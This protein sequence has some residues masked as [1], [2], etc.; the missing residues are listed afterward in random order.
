M[1]NLY[2]Y[3]ETTLKKDSSKRT[4]PL[5]NRAY[6]VLDYLYNNNEKNSTEDYVC[7]NKNGNIAN[8][9]NITRTLNAMLVRAKCDVQKCGLHALRH[10]FGSFLV[11][12]GVDIATVSKLMGHRDIT[13]TYNIY[14]H[15][16]QQQ[17][18]DAINV[19]DKKKEDE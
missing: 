19:F 8:Q 18:I 11:S 3:E 5:S 4:I 10:S 6:E 17:Q 1:K 14:I 13:T 15:V 16:L 12:E 7:L 9:R 2:K